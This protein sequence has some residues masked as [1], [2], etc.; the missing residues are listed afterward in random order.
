MQTGAAESH[1]LFFIVNET[2]DQ[3]AD[4]IETLDAQSV[5]L[6]M[7]GDLL[8]AMSAILSMFSDKEIHVNLFPS[9]G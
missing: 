9:L 4:R 5:P 2:T 3:H 8:L 6:K 1:M 7:L